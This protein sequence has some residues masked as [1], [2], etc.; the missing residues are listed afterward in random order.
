M[1]NVTKY[2]SNLKPYIREQDPLEFT[3]YG[4]MP[5]LDLIGTLEF[6]R[7]TYREFK[8]MN[9]IVNSEKIEPGEF[10]V[11]SNI[12][13]KLGI[14]TIKNTLAILKHARKI[15]D[16]R[17]LISLPIGEKQNM[18]TILIKVINNLEDCTDPK[19]TFVKKESLI[20]AVY[21]ETFSK[22]YVPC[23]SRAISECILYA[24]KWNKEMFYTQ[25]KSN[26]IISC[27]NFTIRNASNVKSLIANLVKSVGKD[28]L[29]SELNNYKC[30]RMAERV[31]RGLDPGLNF[32][33]ELAA[34]Q[35]EELGEALYNLDPDILPD[36]IQFSNGVLFDDMQM[37]DVMDFMEEYYD[38]EPREYE[39]DE[40]M[41]NVMIDDEAYTIIYN[42]NYFKQLILTF[43]GR[44][45][46]DLRVLTLRPWNMTFFGP[47]DLTKK[48]YGSLEFYYY[49][50]HKN[51]N[52]LEEVLEITDIGEFKRIEFKEL[53]PGEDIPTCD[54][55]D[56]FLAKQ[57]ID[58][59][60]IR[61]LMSKT[62]IKETF[63]QEVFEFS[64]TDISFLMK[65]VSAEWD[66]LE[67]ILNNAFKHLIKS[68]RQKSSIPGFTRLLFD[69]DLAAEM[70]CLFGNNY[71]H[72]LSGN[73]YLTKSTRDFLI[74]DILM[75]W[76][77]ADRKERMFYDFIL[78]IIKESI[79]G[80]T[81]DSWFLDS[82]LSILNNFREKQMAL[83]IESS[84]LTLDYEVDPNS[85][86]NY[87]ERYEYDDFD[88]F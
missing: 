54:T 30:M 46:S 14:S 6:S 21:M 60:F 76:K 65:S 51:G 43:M 85:A 19:N 9:K 86:L 55:L 17:D 22:K 41:G 77:N 4:D 8:I 71:H 5:V 42:Y 12:R 34:K 45:F 38:M 50:F 88:D 69:E 40:E 29:N 87:E 24:Y 63:K 48:R 61:N 23:I 47:H 64:D 35:K 58:D 84:D 72:V 49:H 81:S 52:K 56:D 74:R 82:V 10:K 67:A 2:R 37:N 26:P 18:V 31:T 59:P 1:Q 13:K 36:Y 27:F 7:L 73:V 68:D 62:L 44:D 57:G 16:F 39:D 15:N 66:N 80:V 32:D 20:T 25:T 3:T 33:D 75:S 11:L 79:I 53:T 70:K 78:C 83:L 28:W